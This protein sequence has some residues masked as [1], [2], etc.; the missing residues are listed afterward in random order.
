MNST[1]LK[2][3]Y[4]PIVKFKNCTSMSNVVV[5]KMNNLIHNLCNIFDN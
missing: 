5:T 1:E 4:L 2:T 3:M